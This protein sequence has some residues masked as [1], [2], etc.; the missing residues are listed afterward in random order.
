MRAPKSSASGHQKQKVL[1]IHINTDHVGPHGM[2]MVYGSTSDYVGKIKGTVKFSSNYDCRGRDIAILYEAKAEAQWTAL[3]NK[4]IVNHHTEEIFGHHIW[5]FPLTHTKPNGST[6]AAGVYEKEFEIPLVHPSLMN[7]SLAPSTAVSNPSAHTLTPPKN[8]LPAGSAL[9]LP[10][11]SYSPHAKMKYTIRAILHRPFPCITN[12]EAS[13]EIWVLNSSLPPLPPPR[14]ISPGSPPAA[15]T[16]KK[17]GHRAKSSTSD[18]TSTSNTP[19]DSGLSASTTPSPSASSVPATTTS[20]HQESYPPRSLLVLTIPTKVIKSALSMLPTLD[21]S[22]SKSSPPTPPPEKDS[23]SIPPIEQSEHVQEQQQARETKRISVASSASNGSSDKSSSSLSS[24]ISASTAPRPFSDKTRR[25]SIISD[26]SLTLDDDEKSVDYTGVWEPFQIPYLCSLP[27]ETV[28]LGQVVPLTIQFG[29]RKNYRRKSSR[30]RDSERQRHEKNG[31]LVKDE[32]KTQGPSTPSTR[33]IVKKG[34]LKVVEHTLLREVTVVPAPPRFHGATPNQ[35]HGLSVAPSTTNQTPRSKLQLFNKRQ[36]QDQGNNDSKV[37][38]LLQGLAKKQSHDAIYQEKNYSGSH[39]H[40]CNILHHEQQQSRLQTDDPI[41]RR[42]SF[43]SLKRRSLDVSSGHKSSA[44]EASPKGFHTA[45][46]TL[47]G[48]DGA[49]VS[50]A[51]P[52]D[53]PP[54]PP[55]L[56][57][58]NN[59]TRIVSSIEAKFKTEVM[60]LSLTPLLQQRE[61]KYQQRLYNKHRPERDGHEAGDDEEDEGEDEDGADEDYESDYEEDVWKTT[62]WI[63]LPGPSEL[64]TFTETKHIVKKHTLQLILLCGLAANTSNGSATATVAED[65]SPRQSQGSGTRL[66]SGSVIT[67]PG[68]NKEFR[69]EMDLHV[70]GPR[71]P[72]TI[73]PTI[74]T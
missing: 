70:T 12:F 67:M 31:K 61:H 66:L 25:D 62:V 9:L 8:T 28:Y 1:S 74:A 44:S 46:I 20:D 13:Q 29:P 48:V 73:V 47:T 43:F 42:R 2:P 7:Q 59:N 72:V 36:Q 68:I 49:V 6:V 10:S 5:H 30:G 34:I 50:L 33:L 56:P 27:S 11:S 69:L 55:M 60:I 63:H 45:P 24:S 21:L 18:T 37:P 52:Q 40:L 58:L 22:L 41:E 3:E 4:K 64:A 38:I 35:N 23:P 39:S 14:P 54:P 53:L 17:R 15:S 71:A 65:S 16:H 51:P 26:N 19:A 32:I 57:A